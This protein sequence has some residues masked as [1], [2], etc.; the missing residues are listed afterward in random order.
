MPIDINVIYFYYTKN[1]VATWME[2]QIKIS[3]VITSPGEVKYLSFTAG[4]H[5]VA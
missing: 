4:L 1:I 5:F 2:F 3:F